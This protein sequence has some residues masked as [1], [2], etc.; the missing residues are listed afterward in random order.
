MTWLGDQF[1]NRALFRRLIVAYLA[2]YLWAAT[3]KSF[4]FAELALESKLSGAEIG[5][6]ITALVA[7]PTAIIGYI[8]KVYSESRAD[9]TAR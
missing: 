9:D 7:L 3:D 5:G 6:I 1:E 2:A 8:F 4:A